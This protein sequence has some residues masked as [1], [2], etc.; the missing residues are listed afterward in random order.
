MLG[1]QVSG[2][3][4][5]IEGMVK[6]FAHLIH[7]V[8]FIPNGNRTYFKGRSQP[9]FFALMLD[10]LAEQKGKEIYATYLKFLE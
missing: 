4:D 10:I 2:R 9:P 1:L 5:L 7:T 6:N 3:T 8:G